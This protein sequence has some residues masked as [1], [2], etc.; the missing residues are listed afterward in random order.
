MHVFD[1]LDV[2]ASH[3]AIDH[4]ANQ[5]MQLCVDLSVPLKKVTA[6][7]VFLRKHI[8]HGFTNP[9]PRDLS[10]TLITRNMG[11]LLMMPLP[12]A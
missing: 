1:E 11:S 5:P 7:A 3:E 12:C 9:L 8:W 4:E 10:A 6:A 2:V